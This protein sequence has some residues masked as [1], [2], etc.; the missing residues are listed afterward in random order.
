MWILEATLL[1]ENGS[2]ISFLERGVLKQVNQGYCQVSRAVLSYPGDAN[3]W[4]VS[5]PWEIG[6]PYN[7]AWTTDDTVG[8]F[9]VRLQYGSGVA[10][11]TSFRLTQCEEVNSLAGMA[12]NIMCLS[13]AHW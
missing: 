12:Q 7:N 1:R 13:K 4:L 9:R 8:L 10:Q 2:V 5:G 11:S 6:I 3:N